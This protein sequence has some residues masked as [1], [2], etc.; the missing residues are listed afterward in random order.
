MGPLTSSQ[1]P[2]GRPITSISAA[3]YTPQRPASSTKFDPL[4]QGII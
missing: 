3:N 2:G 4:N 1:A